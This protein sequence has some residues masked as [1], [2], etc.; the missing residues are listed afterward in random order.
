MET[1]ALFRDISIL[2]LAIL[3]LVP[4]AIP[5]ALFFFAQKY[6]R[7][8]RKRLVPL[9]RLGSL[10]AQRVQNETDRAARRVITVPIGVQANTT[11]LKVTGKSLLRELAS[12]IDWR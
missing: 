11:R 8:G 7:L 12:L 4:I 2:W 9:L 5:G 1:T 3:C 10:W 6:L